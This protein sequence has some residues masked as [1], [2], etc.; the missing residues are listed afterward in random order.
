MRRRRSLSIFRHSRPSASLAPEVQKAASAAFCIVIPLRIR[1]DGTE[2]S[3]LL[4]LD[5]GRKE[6][7]GCG[8]GTA[9]VTKLQRPQSVYFDGFILAIAQQAFKVSGG[10]IKGRDLPAAK[11]THE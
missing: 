4:V 5:A 6:Q 8:A 3:M 2:Q 10:W 1:G 11:H 7:R 9:A